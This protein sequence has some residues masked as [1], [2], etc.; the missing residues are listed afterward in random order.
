LL[1]HEFQHVKLGALIDQYT[2]YD[3]TD[4]KPRHYAP[5]RPDPRP[6]EGL[7]QGTYAHIA[8]TD[9]WRVRR[10]MLGGAAGDAA[11]TQFAR[12]REHTAEAVEQL[13]ASGSLTP[14]G[15]RFVRAM[16]ETVAP[17]RE[18]PV[19]AAALADARRASREHRAA[20]EHLLA[21]AP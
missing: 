14:L 20:Y 19:A 18:E 12:W 6:F 9:F 13:L 15:E 5:W 7:F 2:L 8:V 11:E 17:W 1:V 10:T 3:K 21:S 16:G 4:T